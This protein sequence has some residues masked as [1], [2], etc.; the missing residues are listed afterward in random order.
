MPLGLKAGVRSGSRGRNRF[1]KESVTA[2]P[3]HGA[4]LSHLPTL[5]MADNNKETGDDAATS[6][7][8]TLRDGRTSEDSKSGAGSALSQKDSDKTTGDA[9]ASSASKT[10]RSNDTGDD[11]KSSSGSALSQ[12]KGD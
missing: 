8:K 10:L 6:A 3:H 12:K 1:G 2:E 5:I 7:S 4:G 11:S 9:A